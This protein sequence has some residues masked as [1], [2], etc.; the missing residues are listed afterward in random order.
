[1]RINA[2]QNQIST[3]KN[4]SLHVIKSGFVNAVNHKSTTS[5][6]FLLIV[7]SS[8]HHKYTRNFIL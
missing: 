7:K 4:I 3:K 6:K 1:M 5:S 2:Q 8:E